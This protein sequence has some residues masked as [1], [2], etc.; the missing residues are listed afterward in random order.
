MGDRLTPLWL[1]PFAAEAL[2]AFH[3]GL[4]AGLTTS[5]ALVVGQVASFQD[6]WTFRETIARRLGISARTVQRAL[7]EAQDLGLIG[8]ARSKPGEVPPGLTN[9]VYCGWS[10]RWTIG[11][12]Q[13]AERAKAAIAQARMVRLAKRLL[14]TAA[15]PKREVERRAA[16]QVKTE[17]AHRERWH[18]EPRRWT[19]EELDAELERRAGLA[20]P[21]PA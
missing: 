1:G 2:A 16:E 19:A 18:R 13:A 8:K 9:E 15:A 7:T 21:V 17:Q 20:P 6:C 3:R 12:G 5:R 14:A 11:W 10:H 4:E